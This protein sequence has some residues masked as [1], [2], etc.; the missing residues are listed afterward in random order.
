MET[1]SKHDDKN[2]IR[3]FICFKNQLLVLVSDQGFLDHSSIV[4]ETL[5]DIDNDS[6]FTDGYGRI[7]R[8]AEPADSSREFV[9]ERH[10]GK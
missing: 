3:S 8:K 5:T 6:L 2:F 1:S 9:M 4:F 7:W 10:V